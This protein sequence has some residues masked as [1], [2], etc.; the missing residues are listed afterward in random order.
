V[1]LLHEGALLALDEPE[2]LQGALAGQLLEVVVDAPRLPIELLARVPGV[3]DV[4]SFGDRAHVRTSGDAG[5]LAGA[6]RTALA[7]AGV[8][9]IGVRPIGASLEDVFIDLIT[10]GRS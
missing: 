5:A 10:G 2:R 8:P 1:A 4:Q 9:A 7:E 6:L 3:R